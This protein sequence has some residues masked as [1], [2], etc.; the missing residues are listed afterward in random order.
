MAVPL[1]E[2]RLIRLKDR[3]FSVNRPQARLELRSMRKQRQ[4]KR[5]REARIL[6]A[7]GRKNEG[8]EGKPSS[9]PQGPPPG[10][11]EETVE[12]QL[13][14]L[15]RLRRRTRQPKRLG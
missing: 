12:E 11:R 4:E 7:P 6:P 14:R 10:F 9:G 15:R 13:A 8:T 1:W 5:E 3:V 2:K